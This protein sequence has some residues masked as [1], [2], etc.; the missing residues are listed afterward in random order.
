[1]LCLVRE[2]YFLYWQLNMFLKSVAEDNEQ[3]NTEDVTMCRE[4][5]KMFF[6]LNNKT[7][8]VTENFFNVK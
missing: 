6:I 8:F 2:E 7:Y 4:L 3:N 5:R 1:M